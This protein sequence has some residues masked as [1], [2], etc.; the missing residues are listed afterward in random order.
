[1]PMGLPYSLSNQSRV[2]HGARDSSP[3]GQP[4][5]NKTDT[6]PSSH[7]YHQHIYSPQSQT[8]RVKGEEEG[9]TGPAAP[10]TKDTEE[11]LEVVEVEAATVGGGGG[12]GGRRRKKTP[13]PNP[14]AP[15]APPGAQQEILERGGGNRRSPPPSHR[16]LRRPPPPH[17]LNAGAK[18]YA[19]S[20]D[21]GGGPA[22]QTPYVGHHPTP[23]H[24]PQ[25]HH[26]QHQGSLPGS[27]GGAG[28]SDTPTSENASD[29]TLTD[30]ELALAR[31]STLLVQ[32]GEWTNQG[33]F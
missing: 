10:S 7:Y 11:S 8:T 5:A 21:G 3:S 23:H 28:L 25:L 9:V 19:R 29:A 20:L 18:L 27:G 6:I 31:D 33:S 13:A 24:L 15:S 12:G 16:S 26:H 30:S 14:S 1:M 2:R 32:N 4:A 17:P 22:Y